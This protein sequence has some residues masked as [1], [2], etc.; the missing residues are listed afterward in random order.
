VLKR[1]GKGVKT[2]SDCYP[3]SG[4]WTSPYDGET[5]TRASDVDIDHLIPLK[6]AWESGAHRWNNNER[7]KLAND[8]QHPQ[9]WAVTDNINQ[10]KSDR[11]PADWK[12]PVRA[13]WCRYAGAWIDVKHHYRLTVDA[14]EKK[15]LRAMLGRC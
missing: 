3:E 10:S 13:F 7:E 2:G 5:W 8:L 11:D 4:R 6:E 12:P 1:D 15:A 14:N 9:L